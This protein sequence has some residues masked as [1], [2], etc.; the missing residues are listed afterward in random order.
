MFEPRTL[1][2]YRE[3][4]RSDYTDVIR[5]WTGDNA[6]TEAFSFLYEKYLEKDYLPEEYDML[7]YEYAPNQFHTYGHGEIEEE[8]RVMR[9]DARGMVYPTQLAAE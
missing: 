8:L 3:R 5:V 4:E 1:L 7:I 2:I 6:N 9:N